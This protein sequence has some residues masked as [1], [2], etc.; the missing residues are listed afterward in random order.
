MKA[1]L[2]MIAMSAPRLVAQEPSVAM[3][4]DL[5][6]WG[7]D[8]A[9]LSLQPGK[10]SLTALAFRYS[11]PVSYSG[12]AVIEIYKTGNGETRKLPE[13]SA[14]DLEHQL[15]PLIAEESKPAPGEAAKPKQGL[16]LELEKRREKNPTLVAL[17]AL[18]GSGCRRATIL[19]APSRR[20]HLH[21]LRDRRR[22]KQAP[23]GPAARSQPE[24]F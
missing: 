13:P 22:S 11:T 7:D 14:E 8:I 4:I 10:S 24:S 12:P 18:P 3:K 17:A 5:V 6:A 2:L 19:L 16:A 21:D 15:K 1:F 9:G 23:D 20:R